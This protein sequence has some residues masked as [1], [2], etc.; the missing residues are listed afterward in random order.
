MWKKMKT[1]C[2]LIASNFA[3]RSPYW[4][5]IKKISFRYC[6]IYLRLRSICGTWNSSQ[7]TS[8]PCLS[9]INMV[10]NDANKKLDK[11]LR[12]DKVAESLK[13]G[14]FFETQCI[15][16][17]RLPKITAMYSN[18]PKSCTNTADLFFL[19][20][21]LANEVWHLVDP[22]VTNMVH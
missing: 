5:Q 8:L 14:T 21:T 4:L 6:F 3:S 2:I 7:Q 22:S 19:T 12:F 20:D 18:L 17:C 1:N 15:S 10:W 13:V 11:T 16:R 9:T